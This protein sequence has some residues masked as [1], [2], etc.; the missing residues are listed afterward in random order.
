MIPRWFPKKFYWWGTHLLPRMAIFAKKCCS[1][2]LSLTKSMITFCPHYHLFLKKFPNGFHDLRLC[3]P[4]EQWLTTHDLP[5]PLQ[6]KKSNNALKNAG[7]NV[8]GADNQG[9]EK[10]YLL[11]LHH[12]G[13]NCAVGEDVDEAD[14]ENPHP[15][16]T[17]VGKNS[18]SREMFQN[19]GYS[20]QEILIWASTS[21]EG[22]D[23]IDH[24]ENAQD[25]AEGANP[26]LDLHAEAELLHSRHLGSVCS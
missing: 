25:T 16:S 12:P 4:K 8:K 5:Q 11:V 20:Q 10:H 6:E 13:E 3:L 1:P 7:D 14:T 18:R 2:H 23:E 15:V 21:E 22:E 24:P 19:L 26:C 9:G 17:F